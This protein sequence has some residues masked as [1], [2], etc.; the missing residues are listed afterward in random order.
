MGAPKPG[1]R[2]RLTVPA[3]A[4][5]KV[6]PP[7]ERRPRASGGPERDGKGAETTQPASQ[8]DSPG[9]DVGAVSGETATP[10]R[11]K[12]KS[13]RGRA[14]SDAQSNA[15]RTEG[16]LRRPPG[17]FCSTLSERAGGRRYFRAGCG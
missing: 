17:F 5:R 14:R 6:P 2:G 15:V 13:A 10:R 16:G 8:D 7:D 11:S 9:D 12:S 4:P 3:R 1:G